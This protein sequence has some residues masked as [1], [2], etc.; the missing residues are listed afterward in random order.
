MYKHKVLEEESFILVGILRFVWSR[1]LYVFVYY[2]YVE[3]PVRNQSIISLFTLIIAFELYSPGNTKTIRKSSFA[4]ISTESKQLF[5]IVVRLLTTSYCALGTIGTLRGIMPL[6]GL[7]KN[8]FYRTSPMLT[9]A[10][11][12]KLETLLTR[13]SSSSN[14]LTTKRG[15]LIND[16][17]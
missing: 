13:W 7:N 1:I 17:S 8:T 9:K 2:L 11:T 3:P 15:M 6:L 4:R 16:Y 12:R 5:C 14:G 10:S